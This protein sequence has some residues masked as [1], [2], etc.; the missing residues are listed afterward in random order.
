MKSSKL[1]GRAALV[2]ALL[3]LVGGAAFAQL[4]SGNLYG[5][6]VD[7]KGA[8]LPGV[9][10]TLS[11]AGAPQVQVTNAQ[12]QF[13]FLGLPPGTLHLTAQLEGFSSVEYPNINIAV[14]RNTTI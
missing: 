14:G 2:A 7:D 9:T 12:G 10:V 4:Q 6:V 11:G 13:R 3:L 1:L 8:P 5:S